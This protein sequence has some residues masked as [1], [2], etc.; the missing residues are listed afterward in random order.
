M[1]AGGGIVA[2][3]FLGAALIVLIEV[4]NRAVRRPTDLVRTFGIMPIATIPYMRTPSETMMRRTAFATILL[5]AVL[6]I[7]AMVYAVHVYYAPL[8]IIV[9]KIV[10]KFGIRL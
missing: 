2:G 5:V 8:D 4:L 7:P 3:A 9:G 10:S 1:I 6:G